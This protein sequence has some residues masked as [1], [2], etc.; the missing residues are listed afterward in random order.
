M[1]TNYE[2]N[3]IFFSRYKHYLYGLTGTIAE[4]ITK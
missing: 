3:V 1:V 2:S 4:S